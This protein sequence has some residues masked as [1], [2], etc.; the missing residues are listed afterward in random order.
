MLTF[1]LIVAVALVVAA[2]FTVWVVVVGTRSL[3]RLI[4]GEVNAPAVDRVTT[5][6]PRCPHGGCGT[7]NPAQARFCRRCGSP[8]TTAV[9]QSLPPRAHRSPPLTALR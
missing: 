2:A 8:M 4:A 1:L 9:P 6:G 3:W 5:A 7:I